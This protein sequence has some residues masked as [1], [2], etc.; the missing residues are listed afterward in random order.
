MDMTALAIGAAYL[1][2]SV[3]ICAFFWKMLDSRFASMDARF[4]SIE[5]RLGGVEHKLDKLADD[6]RD[7]SREL[8]ELRGA[9]G[10]A[11]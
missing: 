4:V 7:L 5:S 8:S 3:A 11:T 9:I 2:T 1:G 10:G 6:H